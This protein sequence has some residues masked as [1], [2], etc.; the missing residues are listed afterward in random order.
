MPKLYWPSFG[1]LKISFGH[2][3]YLGRI[4]A[5]FDW[6]IPSRNIQKVCERSSAWCL[7]AQRFIF[8][9][10]NAEMSVRERSSASRHRFE[11]SP[12]LVHTVLYIIVGARSGRPLTGKEF[13]AEGRS[14]KMLKAED[15][16]PKMLK[17]EDRSLENCLKR[18]TA[19]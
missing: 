4:F 16:S 3:R 19:H 18:K 12:C 14:L 1:H 7:G 17:A 2:L 5:I 13:E 11:T 6:W 15:R 8:V 10:A 9:C